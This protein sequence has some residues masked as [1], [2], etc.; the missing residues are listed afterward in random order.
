MFRT[1]TFLLPSASFYLCK[2]AAFPNALI[3]L[4]RI[5]AYD[6]RF[7][8]PDLKMPLDKLN[9]RKDG[10]KGVPLTAAGPANHADPLQ[11]F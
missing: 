8:H 2:W 3:I 7:F 4:R 1:D 10:K 5:A 6:F 9:C 11:R